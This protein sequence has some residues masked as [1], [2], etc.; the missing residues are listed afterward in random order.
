MAQSREKKKPAQSKAGAPAAE[1]K[2]IPGRFA[3]WK[4]SLALFLFWLVADHLTKWWAIMALKPEY[5]PP[6]VIDIIPG[7]LRLIY[8]EN[9]GAAFS[10]LEGQTFLLGLISLAAIAGL[11]WFWYILPAEEVWGRAAVALVTSGAVGNMIDRFGR[12][13][14]VDFI[15][16]YVGQYHWPTFNIADSCICVGAAILAFRFLKG[17]I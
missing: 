8:A 12:G 11:C 14:V 4:P 7:F 2:P 6:P 15:D 10:L 5:L 9:T 1:E 17:K 16:A 13:Y 3:W